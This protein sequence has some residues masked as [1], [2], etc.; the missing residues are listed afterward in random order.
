M[1]GHQGTPNGRSRAAGYIRVSQ[2]RNVDRHG[3]DSQ[4]ADVDRYVEFMQWELSEVYR[5]EGVSGYRSRSGSAT[6]ASASCSCAR[7][8]TRRRP[9]A[10][11]S[12]T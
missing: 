12:A 11:S 8:S 5:E 3:L 4:Q 2:E 7:G 6:A 1:P 10:S 9:S